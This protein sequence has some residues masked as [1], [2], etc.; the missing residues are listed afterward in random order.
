MEDVFQTINHITR[1]EEKTK[2]YYEPNFEPMPQ[3]SKERV[4]EVCF[5]K[6]TKPNSPV[7]AYNN[8][9]H[10]NQY[11]SNSRN[12][13]KQ[14]SGHFHVDQCRHQYKHRPGKL[15]CYYC[16]GE[17]LFRGCEKFSKDNA[18]YNLKTTELAKKYKD[19][20]RQAVKKG[21]ITVTEVAFSNTQELTYSMEQA[22]QL[23][24]NLH[25]SDSESD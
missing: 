20:L 9:Q 17:H 11:S 21:N 8:S 12:G 2:A 6:Y 4:H 25:F 1:T 15:E 16:E 19:N 22:E 13:S 23:L 7:K 5:S 3:V 14:H 24:G 10:N 18:K